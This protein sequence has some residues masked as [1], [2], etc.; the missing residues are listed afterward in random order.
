MV[1]DTRRRWQRVNTRRT[2][3]STVSP[4]PPVP[5]STRRSSR[6]GRLQRAPRSCATKLH[7]TSTCSRSFST[8]THVLGPSSWYETRG[9]CCFRRRTG[10]DGVNVGSTRCLVGIN[11]ASGRGITRSRCRTSGVRRPRSVS[12]S[13]SI[14]GFT[15]FVSRISSRHRRRVSAR[16]ATQRVF[17]SSNV[18]SMC[19]NPARVT[20]LS[21]LVR[22][23]SIGTRSA[24]GAA[25]G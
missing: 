12:A 13:A 19:R 9:M 10:G 6:I 8:G 23:G 5:P 18:F 1:S 20:V 11:C 4:T 24:G 17:R 15:S 21:K 25:G 7:A 14:P 3:S 22:R 2:P 16:C